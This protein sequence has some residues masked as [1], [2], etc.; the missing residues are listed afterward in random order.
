[1]AEGVF[2]ETRMHTLCHVGQEDVGPNPGGDIF[3][4]GVVRFLVAE[5]LRMVIEP[6]HF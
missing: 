3:H 5:T 4:H 2:E 6:I 1:M